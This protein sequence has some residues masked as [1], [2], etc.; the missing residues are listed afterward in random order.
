MRASKVRLA[1]FITA[2][3]MIAMLAAGFSLAQVVSNGSAVTVTL[4]EQ[5]T[6][7]LLARTPEERAFVAH[8][9]AAVKDETLPLSLVQS[10]FL[11]ARTRQPYPMPYFQRALKLRAK[12]A[13]IRF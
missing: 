11:W 12:A 4:N 13:G 1:I 5:L 6:A 3:L 9:V 10:T 2:S 7:G 8:V